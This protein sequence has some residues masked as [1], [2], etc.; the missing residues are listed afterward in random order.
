MRHPLPRL[1]FASLVLA[2]APVGAQSLD[3]YVGLGAAGKLDQRGLD[4]SPGKPDG[5]TACTAY[6]G[7][8]HASGFGAELAYVDLG[9]LRVDNLVDAGYRVDGELWSLGATYRIDLGDVEPFAKLGWFRR[10]DDGHAS[11]LVGVHR[12]KVED[13]GL[14][15]ELGV[16]WR[17]TEALALRAGYAWYDFDG[18][19][20]GSVQVAAEWHF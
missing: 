13:D 19:R 12:F 18:G 17:A 20:D 5:E 1:I 4:G 2:A 8:S 7:V 3:W 16:R 14:A 6:L 10:Q 9:R 11:T 15:A